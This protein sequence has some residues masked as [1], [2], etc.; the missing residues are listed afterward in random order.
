M[1]LH[2]LGKSKHMKSALKWTKP[3]K[4]I[5]DIVDSSFEKDKE[6]LI[7]FGTNISDITSYQMAIQ[8]STSPNICCCIT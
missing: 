1:L 2:Y 6:M 4:T 8:I 3:P 7:V 5:R